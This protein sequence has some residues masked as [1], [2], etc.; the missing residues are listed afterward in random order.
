MRG[1]VRP[2][3]P[4]SARTCAAKPARI[5]AFAGTHWQY[6]GVTDAHQAPPDE[7]PSE[8]PSPEAPAIRVIEQRLVPLAGE[9][10]GDRIVVTANH[11][12]VV[13]AERNPDAADRL[14]AVVERLHPDA[15]GAPLIAELASALAPGESANIA[16]YTISTQTITHVGTCQTFWD[17]HRPRRTGRAVDETAAAYRAVIIAAHL[18]A[19]S[20]ADELRRDDPGAA[21]LE[22]LNAV[23]THLINSDTPWSFGAIVAG[24]VPGRYVDEVN[25]SGWVTEI[26]LATD[27]YPGALK[28]LESA[29]TYL[30][31]VVAE[32]P[33]Q[34]GD[35]RGMRAVPV[36]G[37]AVDDR[38]YVRLAIAR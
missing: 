25:V 30:A 7:A 10:G 38:A 13:D 11:A 1:E 19:G 14:A 5:P 37:G 16:I 29:E 35:H 36:G 15:T 21:A 32:D 33:L 34:A 28:T 4:T 6:S 2:R 8:P 18:A 22:Q 26:V 23:R 24:G 12:A 31:R 17:G 3:P 27:G 9:R 20:S